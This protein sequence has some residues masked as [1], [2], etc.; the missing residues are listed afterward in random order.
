MQEAAL[1]TLV[2]EAKRE[3]YASV[4]RAFEAYYIGDLESR[5]EQLAHYSA[6][7]GNPR[8]AIHW[9]DRAAGH[10]VRVGATAEAF[11]LWSRA[12][13][14]SEQIGDSDAQIAFEESLRALR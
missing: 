13:A 7:A 10:A 2:P 9:L 6:Q 11:A 3:L 12:Q 4:A 14:L 5:F 8:T 1:S